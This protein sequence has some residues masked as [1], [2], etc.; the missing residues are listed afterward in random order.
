MNTVTKII[1]FAALAALGIAGVT[2]GLI[3][4]KAATDKQKQSHKR[5]SKKSPAGQTAPRA[6][7]FAVLAAVSGI[8]TLI[9]GGYCGYIVYIHAVPDAD[10]VKTDIVIAENGYQDERFTAD[11]VVYEVLPLPANDLVCE[12]LATPIFTYK[13]EG[14]LNG[15]LTGN[16]YSIENSK[17]FTLVWNGVDNLFAPAEERDAILSYYFGEAME[18]NYY[19]YA[20]ADWDA[21]PQGVA[22]S[23]E[24]AGA[25]QAYLTLD[26]DSLATETVIPEAYETIAIEA[27][28]SDGIVAYD[29]WFVVMEGKV[30]VQL[31]SATTEDQREELT[32]APL[33]DEISAPLAKLAE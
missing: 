20:N 11:G 8:V 18:W 6:T 22:L 10:Y 32:L 4:R 27:D 21:D 12:Q 15:Y 9:S 29:F 1:L 16:Y 26:T 23:E 17:G 14:F 24:A 5:K 2:C 25:M 13:T 30:Y 33:P 7:V 19:D 31:G 3:G 28:S